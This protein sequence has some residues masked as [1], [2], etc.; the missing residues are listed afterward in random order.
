MT[1]AQLIECL[2]GKVGAIKG[3]EVDGTS[4]NEIDIEKVKD[5]LESLGYERNATEYMY[6][7][8]T[9]QRLRIPIFIGPTYYQR[10]KHLVM[11]KMHCLRTDKCEV[12]TINGWKK[13]GEF[14][15]NDL[16]ATLVNNKLVY[17][18]PKQIFYYPNI[19]EEMY[20]I[21]NQNI[22]FDVTMN[23]RMWVSKKYGRQQKWLDYDFEYAKDIIGKQRRYKKDA[24]WDTPDYQFILPKLIDGN[25]KLHDE[26]IVD[27]NSWI[28]FFGIWIAEGWAGKEN[29]KVQLAVNKQRV[30]DV[31][32]PALRTL[33]YEYTV[34][35]EK[36]TI[37]DIQLLRYMQNYSVGAPN[38]YLPEWCFKLSKIQTQ[39]LINSMQLGDGYFEKNSDVS[40][41]STSSEKLADQFQQLCL[42]A[43]YA[44]NK[45]KHIEAYENEVIIDN[46]KVV[47][48]HDIWRISV[49]KTKTRPG[50]N[51]GHVKNQNIQL[52]N[53]YRY[54]GDVFCLEVNSGV[55][56]VRQNGKPCWTANSRAR[57]PITMLTHQPPEGRLISVAVRIKVLA[58]SIVCFKDIIKIKSNYFEQHS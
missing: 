20:H 4:F 34:L 44:S 8:M 42:H 11:D 39:L 26:I 36:L 32:Y 29:R 3:M 58:S 41:Y 57:G 43:G 1:I 10:L 50:V 22:E 56:M 2:M 47:N 53:T 45:Y 27:M 52:E 17:E 16:V 38:K 30:K 54:N 28:I 37:C 55:F 7:G 25:N 9:G 46:R 24:E 35:D 6:N 49:M 33:G 5:M 31:L 19:N 15:T 23:H 13:Y 12:L 40:W 14:T 51:H 48:Q 18:K 21:S